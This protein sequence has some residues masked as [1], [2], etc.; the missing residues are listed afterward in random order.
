MIKKFLFVL[1]I[2]LC[3]TPLFSQKKI[4]VEDIWQFGTFRV[5]GVPGFNFLKDGKHYSA[6]LDNT[7]AKF[8]LTTG[9]QV[10]TIFESKTPFSDYTFSDEESKILL[11]TESEQIYRRSSKG[12][13]SV[14]DGKTAT[15]LPPSVKHSNPT[16]NPQATHVAYTA[17]N[18]LYI[19]DLRK[20]QVKQVT[21][22]GAPNRIVNGLCDWVYEEEFGFTRAFEWSPDGSK[23]AYLRFDETMCQNTL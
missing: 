6:N 21:K 12:F 17:N 20:N 14:W 3:F 19:K 1:F 22:D 16:F 7:I 18:N 4:T 23:V 5:K 13:Y 8:D 9:K 10:G 15:P 11:A 2:T